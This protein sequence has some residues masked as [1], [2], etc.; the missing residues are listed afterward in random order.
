MNDMIAG[1]KSATEIH[2]RELQ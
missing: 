1:R 2:Y